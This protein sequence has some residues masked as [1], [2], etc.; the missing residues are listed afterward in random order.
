MAKL[1]ANE[2][3]RDARD[4]HENDNVFVLLDTYNDKRSGFFF[5]LN[6]LGAI[7]DR[8]IT[9]SGD[10]MN[11]DWDAVVECKSKINDSYW[12]RRT[13]HPIQSTPI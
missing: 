9:N 1:I 5:R 10:T 12:D 13:Q 6:P 3:R 2:M 4:L 7:Q 11:T 8:A